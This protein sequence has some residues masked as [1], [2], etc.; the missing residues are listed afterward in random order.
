MNAALIAL[1]GNLDSP[2]ERVL[3]AFDALNALPGT[4]LVSRSG[5][6]LSAPISDIPQP[7]YINAVARIDTNLPPFE[8]LD[9]LLGIEAANGRR[10]DSLNAP[11]TLDLDLLMYGDTTMADPRL[12][13][14]HPRLHQRLFVLLPLLEIAPDCV[15]PGIG[16]AD[17]CLN[18]LSGQSISRLPD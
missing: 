1:G 16:R 8:L 7:D 3:G 12:R 14:P 11:R 18:A 2:R 17:G 15:I 5:L 4:R 10:R 9:A 13:L 6:Y